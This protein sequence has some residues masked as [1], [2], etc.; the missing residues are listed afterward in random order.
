MQSMTAIETL[1]RQLTHELADDNTIAIALTGA[2]IP[3]QPTT[4]YTDVDVLRYVRILPPEEQRQQLRYIGETLV[5]VTTGSIMAERKKL[6]R[7]DT[8]V[9]SVLPLKMARPLYDPDGLFAALQSEAHHFRWN[10]DMQRQADAFASERLM[11]LTRT[12]H[13]VMSALTRRDDASLVGGVEMLTV[14]LMQVMTVQRG[15]L[16]AASDAYVRTLMRQVGLGS[17]WTYYMMQA[18]GLVQN[19]PRMRGIAALGLYMKTVDLLR[20][21]LQSSH[22]QVVD[23]TWAIIAASGYNQDNQDTEG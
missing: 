1:L 23:Q 5:S 7:P 21:I 18:V 12:A 4:P 20:P 10:Q 8:A 9:W 11:R 14:G 17:A 22:A 2:H 3:G 15:V 16:L 13:Q 6:A 19:D